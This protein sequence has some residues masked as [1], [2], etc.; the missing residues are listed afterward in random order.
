MKMKKIGLG[1][2]PRLYYV[3]PPLSSLMWSDGISA[4]KALLFGH[5]QLRYD[6]RGGGGDLR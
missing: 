5:R 2:Y 4:Q 6:S 3:D 1:A